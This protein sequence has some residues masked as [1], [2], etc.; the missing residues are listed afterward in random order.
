L[1][2][3]EADARLSALSAAARN[4][5]DVTTVANKIALFMACSPNECALQSVTLREIT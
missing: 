3:V 2:E 4:K 1:I 5:P